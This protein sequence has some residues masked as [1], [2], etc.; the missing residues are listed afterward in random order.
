MKANIYCIYKH[1]SI[2]VLCFPTGTCVLMPMA[3]KYP[4]DSYNYKKYNV[5]ALQ[6]WQ[7]LLQNIY[8]NK[9]G[10]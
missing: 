10:H 6:K 1:Y 5:K 2:Y 7:I 3:Y 8:L 9:K 4:V